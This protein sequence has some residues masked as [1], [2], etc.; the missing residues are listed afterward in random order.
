VNKAPGFQSSSPVR[1]QTLHQ[2]QPPMEMFRNKTR[3]VVIYR[4]CQASP[5]FTG[6]LKLEFLTC[7]HSHITA[8]PT[9]PACEE[10]VFF[11]N[12][13]VFPSGR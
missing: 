7:K 13:S 8:D 5:T 6:R 3:N 11:L 12:E 9:G 4:S 1:Q 10:S 2:Q